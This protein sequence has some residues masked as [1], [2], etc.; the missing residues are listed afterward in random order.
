MV[1]RALALRPFHA[2]PHRLADLNDTSIFR[3]VLSKCAPGFPVLMKLSS[4]RHCY[5]HRNFQLSTSIK[6]KPRN[7]LALSSFGF[8]MTHF[9]FSLSFNASY[10][11]F[12]ISGHT[13]SGLEVV[14]FLVSLT[15]D[16]ENPSGGLSFNTMNLVKLVHASDNVLFHHQR[17]SNLRHVSPTSHL[18][19]CR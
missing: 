14:C 9:W 17:Y 4:R 5:W 2:Y 6:N 10:M 11:C 18:T 3:L 7:L 8:S 15:L 12:H 13:L 1:L 16:Y 19:S